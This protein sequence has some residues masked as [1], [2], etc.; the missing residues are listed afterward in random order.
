MDADGAVVVSL[1]RSTLFSSM[2]PA[3][4]FLNR[5]FL[6][7][8]FWYRYGVMR[9][10]GSSIS[11]ESPPDLGRGYSA[12]KPFTGSTSSVRRAGTRHATR[13]TAPSKTGIAMNVTGSAGS[14]A[15]NHA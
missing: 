13:A 12:R 11:R 14:T 2:P 6:G 15:H 1:R 7:I 8:D 3:S 4:H 10:V 5:R 9:K